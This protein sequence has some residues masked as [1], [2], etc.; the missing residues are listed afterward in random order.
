MLTL[1]APRPG[2]CCKADRGLFARSRMRPP[3]VERDA[4]GGEG[5]AAAA[6]RCTAEG[7]PPLLDGYEVFLAGGCGLPAGRFLKGGLAGRLTGLGSRKASFLRP[8]LRTESFSERAWAIYLLGWGVSIGWVDGRQGA[9]CSRSP[10]L[11][12]EASAKTHCL[13][14]HE[15]QFFMRPQCR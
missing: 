4:S 3:Q 8:Q 11:W 2:I 15:K 5:A 14:A 9:L 1:R 10:F 6:R 7:L 13:G 12:W